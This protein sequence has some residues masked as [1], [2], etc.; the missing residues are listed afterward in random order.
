V[1]LPFIND[2]ISL[3]PNLKPILVFIIDFVQ[4]ITP[5]PLLKVKLLYMYV[6]IVVVGKSECV[7][8]VQVQPTGVPGE[9]QRQCWPAL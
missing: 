4:L 6:A 7:A 9:Q 2:H 5:C 8:C 1:N 3:L